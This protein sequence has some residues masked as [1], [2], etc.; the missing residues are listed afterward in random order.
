MIELF[1]LD[2]KSSVPKYIQIIDSII[3]NISIGNTVIGDKLPSINELSEEFYL[4]RDTVERAYNVLKKRKVL[5][6]IHGK[7]TYIAKTELLGK[8]NI[9]FL[10]NKFS[11]YKMKV[12]N[13]FLKSLG[14]NIHIDLHSY[15]CDEVLFLELLKKY[16]AEY[17]YY[18]IMPHFRTE[19]LSHIDLTDRV[20]NALNEIPK[21]SLVLLD[22]NQHDL[23][24][25]F[26]EVYQDFEN[27]ILSALKVALNKIS[28]YKKLVLFYPNSTFYPYPIRIV[29][30]FKKFCGIHGF[31]FEIKAEVSPS[32]KLEDACL[33]ITIVEDDLVGLVNKVRASKY[34]LGKEVGVIS[35]NDTSLKELLGISVISADF[36]KMGDQAA[37]MILSNNKKKVK[38]PFNYID[39]ESA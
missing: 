1:R 2:A 31:D 37:Q 8:L 18:V 33:Y 14:E 3:H 13:S 7:G 20:K 4:S 17:D 23:E 34:N 32:M 16:R 38:A 21:E 28:K 25:N 11:P 12:Y 26:I 19:N 24:G 10:V 30:G 9:L 6:S 29:R 39:R 22:N 36:D 5:V 15:H 27:D 35:Y